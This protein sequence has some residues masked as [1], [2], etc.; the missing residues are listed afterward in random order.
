MAV[1]L[2]RL[3]AL[4][5]A[6]ALSKKLKTVN[7]QQSLREFISYA[8]AY[9]SKKSLSPRLD[10]ELILSHV[11]NCD[12]VYLYSHSE[13]CLTP[14][15][16][17]AL[18]KFLSLRKSGYPIAY[19]LEKKEF[20][21]HEFKVMPGV[22]IPRPETETLVRAVV[23]HAKPTKGPMKI[24][25]FGTGSGV[26]GLSIL[27][28]LPKAYL[29]AFDTSKKA[30]KVA[31]FNCQ[32]MGL[33]KRVAFYQKNVS[34]LRPDNQDPLFPVD[35]IVANPPYIAYEDKR[36]AKEVLAFEPAKALFSHS[37]GLEHIFSW[38]NT[39]S[40]WL[41][42]GGAYFFEIGAGQHKHKILHPNMKKTA[43]FKDLSGHVRVLK[44]EKL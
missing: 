44:F 13:Q 24:M 37:Q 28:C 26:V 14:L 42:K 21:G 23:S 11:L 7:K 17:K 34:T 29:V 35:I 25:D 39:A 6:L 4:A 31:H 20:Y 32:K 1:L 10:A 5:T 18:Q 15:Q 22:F 9:F 33:T 12:R 2:K 19:I 40:F 38:L 3:E 8:V 16:I 43:E 27:K 30:L 36:V 41:K